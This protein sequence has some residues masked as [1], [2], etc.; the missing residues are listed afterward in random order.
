MAGGNLS[1]RQKMINMMYL[2]LTALL[3]LNV[4]AQ[5]LEAFQTLKESIHSSAVKFDQKNDETVELIKNKVKEEMEQGNDKNK[6]VIDLSDQVVE[7]SRKLKTELKEISDKLEEIAGWDPETGEYESMKEM[8]QNYQ[9]WMG[10]GKEGANAGRGDGAAFRIKNRL[11]GFV[12]WANKFVKENDTTGNADIHFEPMCEDAEKGNGAEKNWEVSTFH[13]KPV[14]ADLAMVEK[15]KMDVSEIEYELLTYL[16]QKLGAVKFKIDSLILVAAPKSEVV[17]A[18]MPFETRLFVSMASDDIHPE[19]LASSGHIKTEDGGNTGVLTIST[20]GG[21]FGKGTFEKELGYS[22][23]A[24]VPTASGGYEELSF[25]G[26]FKVRKP[27]VVITS[28]SVQNLYW[29]CG[30]ALNVD[31]PALGELYN[32]VF[33]ASDA[34]VVTS[35]SD[36]KKVTIVPSGKQCILS[37]SSNT[38]GQIIKVDDVAYKVIKPPRPHL[39]LIVNGKEYDGVSPISKKSTVMVVVKPDHDFVSALPRDARYAIDKVE[40]LVQRSLGAPTKADTEK[41]S[42]KDASKG[43]EFKLGAKLKQDTPGT[44]IYFKIGRIYRINFQ[45]KKVEEKFSER[46]LMMGAVIK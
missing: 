45:N 43:L 44:K 30:N 29:K 16:K 17:V 1:P 6:Y 40:L 9:F 4:S 2:V 25:K 42:G 39:L 12:D 37:V 5:I 38:N 28:A 14:I 36:K 10:A 11:N 35:K 3:A 21:G 13:S 27:E 7:E 18:G 22:V 19:F 15:F 31:V 20:S 34:E 26:N 23:K 46:D 32:P 24:K 33:K 41:G 8:E